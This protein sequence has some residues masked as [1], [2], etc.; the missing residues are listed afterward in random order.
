MNRRRFVGAVLPLVA[1]GTAGC[2]GSSDDGDPS[3]EDTDPG[4]SDDRNADESGRG[5][6]DGDVPVESAEPEPAE[7]EPTADPQDGDDPHETGDGTDPDA[8]TEGIATPIDWDAVAIPASGTVPE[9]RVA[10]PSATVDVE[11]YD[12]AAEARDGLDLGSID[13][14]RRREV[15][16]LVEAA[17]ADGS[18]L[19]LVGATGPSACHDSIEVGDEEPGGVEVGGDG[20]D[21]IGV[22]GR[23]AV[24]D[25]SGDDQRC[26]GTVTFPSALVWAG[27]PDS[28]PERVAMT[29]AD[30]WGEDETIVV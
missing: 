16:S 30:G 26:G 21:E 22:V 5:N 10:D 14:G 6:D 15:E 3:T 27:F 13:G 9:W 20:A 18:V 25:G 19:L 12:S 8:V 11:R 7:P 2:L 1:V 17:D 29:V 24:A 23:A 4:R 28:A